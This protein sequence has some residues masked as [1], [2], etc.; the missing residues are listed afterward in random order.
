MQNVLK[1]D[2]MII[3][4]LVT[5]VLAVLLPLQAQDWRAIVPA[6]T[7]RTE[8]E[9]ILGQTDTAYFAEYK[10]KDGSLFIE[11]SSGPCRPERKGGWNFP[12]NVVVSMTF[13]P[14][15]KPRF[16]EL[17]VDRKKLRKVVDRHVGG[18]IYYI[19]DQDGVVYEIQ[20]GRVDWIEYGPAKKYDHLECRHPAAPKKP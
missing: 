2:D 6:E 7:T 18:V 3:S 15:V 1:R 13:Y 5:Y 16:S 12:T 9:L 10:L 14:A 11:Y 17:T 20:D 4:L 19:N 8:V